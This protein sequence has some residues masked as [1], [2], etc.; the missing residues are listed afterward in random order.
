MSLRWW[1]VF[2]PDRWY[3]GLHTPSTANLEEATIPSDGMR[4]QEGKVP[5]GST[6]RLLMDTGMVPSQPEVGL[7]CVLC[8]KTILKEGKKEEKDPKTGR[9]VHAYNPNTPRG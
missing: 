5:P 8:W 2:L 1:P 9:V 4:R 3:L 6:H 7:Y